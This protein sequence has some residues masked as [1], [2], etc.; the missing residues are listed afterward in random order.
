MVSY[1]YLSLLLFCPV[2]DSQQ[3]VRPCRIYGKI[4][5]TFQIQYKGNYIP[6]SCIQCNLLVTLLL[7]LEFIWGLGWGFKSKGLRIWL[8]RDLCK[9]L[10]VS[11]RSCE[12]SDSEEADDFHKPYRML[13]LFVTITSWVSHYLMGT[14]CFF[15]IV[16]LIML[17]NGH[18][19]I[20]C[21]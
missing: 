8:G 4:Q 15:L 16:G 1:H 3:L 18:V 10:A 7:Q 6:N 17:S 19:L 14:P 5:T 13:R 20:P 9:E 12:K 11:L 21:S 2:W